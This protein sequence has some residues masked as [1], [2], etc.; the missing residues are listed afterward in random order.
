M[1]AA[2]TH[3]H[4]NDMHMTEAEYFAF[5][6]EQPERR[7]E[8][9]AGGVY[10][11]VGGSVTHS[12]IIMSAGRA[13]GNRLAERDYTVASQDVRVRV[14]AV[15]VFRLPDIVIFCGDPIYYQDRTDTI[16]NPILLIE[17]MSP[18]STKRD[19]SDKLTEYKQIESL[20]AYLIVSQ[21]EP[22]VQ[23]FQRAKSGQWINESV[24]GLE[25]Q[26]AVP[27]LAISIALADIYH[28]VRWPSP[29]DETHKPTG[30][31]S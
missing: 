15:D 20:Q 29:D 5:A 22:V 3:P 13:L 10:A 21:D 14:E 23:S 16:T 11:M 2:E 26:I 27:S 19:L 8:Y 28:K 17:V 9:C 12:T 31:K 7:Y 25:S 1:V 18:T 6:D 4:N 30:G 24:V